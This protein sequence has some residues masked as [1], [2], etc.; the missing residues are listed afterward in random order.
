M[1][2]MESLRGRDAR[3][4]MGSKHWLSAEL[5]RCPGVGDSTWLVLLEPPR[6]ISQTRVI[7]QST[8][9]RGRGHAP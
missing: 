3:K 7:Y 1:H 9:L 5:C 8:R 2:C 6:I 4:L